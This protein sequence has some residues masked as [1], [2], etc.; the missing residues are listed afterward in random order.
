MMTHPRSL[1]CALSFRLWNDS[2]ALQTFGPEDDRNRPSIIQVFQLLAMLRVTEGVR[3]AIVG[4]TFA[5][6][7]G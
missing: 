2:N 1:G 7:Q 3:P 5:K 6:L 4:L